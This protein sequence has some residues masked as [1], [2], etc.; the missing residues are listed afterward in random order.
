MYDTLNL[1]PAL[2]S[3][4]SPCEVLRTLDA[5]TH[6]ASCEPDLQSLYG[7]IHR[8][9]SR[10]MV[11]DA[12]YVCR[13]DGH[14]LLEFDYQFDEGVL[15]PGRCEPLGAG[16]TSYC[17]RQQ[18]PYVLGMHNAAV[19]RAALPLGQAKASR[20]AIHVPLMVDGEVIGVL[21]TQSYEPNV[22]N[23]MHV[24]VLTL[25]AAKAAGA[26]R[27]ADLRER[28]RRQVERLNQLSHALRVR[29]QSLKSV[30][31]LV[32]TCDAEGVITAYNQAVCRALGYGPREIVGQSIASISTTERRDWT[33]FKQAKDRCINVTSRNGRTVPIRYNTKTLV[34]EGRPAGFLIVARD[35]SDLQRAEDAGRAALTLERRRIS[36]DL[37]D[38]L[39]QSLS[40]AKMQLHLLQ[41]S[42][43]LDD[44]V[45][46]D[47][48]DLQDTLTRGLAEAR[49]YIVDLK[50]VYLECD[51]L[52]HAARRYT[53]DF[54][55][56]TGLR[57]E[58]AHDTEESPLSSREEVQLFFILREALNNVRKHA[59][60]N[61]VCVHFRRAPG[62]FEMC[63][64]DD[65]CGFDPDAV[66]VAAESDHWG[67]P[68]IRERAHAL[69]GVG[70]IASRP[71]HGTRVSIC[72]PIT[73]E[74]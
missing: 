47:L 63:I 28:N 18:E 52:V 38:G 54:G 61:R 33:A 39:I 22:Y 43:A 58:V 37:H 68:H 53:E 1:L 12:F 49:Q 6:V 23:D 44:G 16:P 7:V 8:E 64:E 24:R 56:V 72:L 36:R 71:G 69:G 48:M 2:N 15:E 67:L 10:I 50:H 59:E 25:V 34:Q 31:D 14:N 60:A 45:R 62:A 11:C 46:R 55:R 42:H 27:N 57:I 26:I 17:V 41:G 20:S 30:G 5:V 19:H 21:S 65:G 3:P 70:E 73:N 51:G 35:L 32:M 74:E 9:I 4:A 40:I 66:E 29:E 13:Y